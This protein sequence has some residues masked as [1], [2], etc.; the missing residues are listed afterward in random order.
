MGVVPSVDFLEDSLSPGVQ[1]LCVREFPLQ[2]GYG[3]RLS[4]D[5]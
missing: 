5:C 4:H 3:L 2:S 1:G